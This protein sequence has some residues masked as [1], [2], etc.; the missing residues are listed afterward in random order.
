MAK[1]P[2]NS[3]T[4]RQ[5]RPRPFTKPNLATVEQEANQKRLFD[6]EKRYKHDVDT[7]AAKAEE[8]RRMLELQ[9]IKRAAEERGASCDVL[10]ASASPRTDRL[11]CCFCFVTS[12]TPGA[13]FSA[14][15][16]TVASAFVR[17]RLSFARA[18]TDYRAATRL[19]CNWRMHYA[20]VAVN[21]IKNPK[22][23]GKKGK[24]GKKKK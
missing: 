2:D 18:E 7:R 5:S 1:S 16:A 9:A 12:R 15:V 6:L 8:E 23:K 20:R 22:K 14:T 3:L 17:S 11:V 19:Q 4:R 13:A 24:G 10:L 21:D